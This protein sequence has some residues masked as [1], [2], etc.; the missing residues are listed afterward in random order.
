MVPL[1][2]EDR[3]LANRLGRHLPLVRL[4]RHQ[5]NQLFLK[6]H[7]THRDPLCTSIRRWRCE[8]FPPQSDV[9]SRMEIAV[10]TAV[11][12]VCVARLLYVWR[13]L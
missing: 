7:V 5:D 10:A 9:R 13:Q 2:P 12:T 8:E 1:V 11:G 6:S 4:H 3:A